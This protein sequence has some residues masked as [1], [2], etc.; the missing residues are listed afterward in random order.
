M[1]AL[2]ACSNR[3]RVRAVFSLPA[4][5]YVALTNVYCGSAN[6]WNVRIELLCQ[7]LYSFSLVFILNAW[8]FARCVLFVHCVAVRSTVSQQGDI[9][10]CGIACCMQFGL[11]PAIFLKLHDATL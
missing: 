4:V 9:R 5:P 10:I 11:I 7:K 3:V 8:M 1:A 2:R 6:T